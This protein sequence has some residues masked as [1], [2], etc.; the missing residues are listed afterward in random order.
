M[1]E[2]L[3]V[4]GL[5]IRMP[6]ARGP[7]TIV[8]DVDFSVAE[9][10]IL[11]IAGESGSGKTMS[12][13]ALLGLAPKT[14]VVGGRAMFE[15]RDLLTLPRGELRKIRGNDIGVVFQDPLTT[16]H[17]MLS[18]GFQLS[19]HMRRHLNIGKREAR[20]RAI[21]LLGEV[22][23]PNADRAVDSFP[24]QFSG[25]M[26]QRIVIAMALACEPKLL[27]ADEPTTA[28]DVT[29]QAGIL[30]LLD[31]LCGNRGMGVLL[32]THDLGVMSSVADRITVFYAGRV[33]ESGPTTEL[34]QRPHHPY[35]KQLLMALPDPKHGDKPLSPIPG[36]PATP[37]NRPPGCAF[38]PRCA[39]A[40]PACSESVP[41]LVDVGPGRVSACP[42]EPFVEIL[43]TGR[44]RDLSEANG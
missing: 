7:L 13:L 1:P 31:D 33:I 18:V 8:D 34:L 35:T 42:V 39:Y 9:G 10:E 17:P 23:I 11:G 4:D 32:V 36:A 24:H 6:G 14:A 41:P 26:R 15:G 37:A 2:L 3:G 44:D 43:G 16:L 38:H 12:V 19:E 22:R 29:V 21:A 30:Q 25:G 28:L 5:R 40:L 20:K 27:I